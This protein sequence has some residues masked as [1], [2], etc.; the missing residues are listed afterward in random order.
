MPLGNFVELIDII[1]SGDLLDRKEL[2]YANL[3]VIQGWIGSKFFTASDLEPDDD[4]VFL[5]M[6]LEDF[7]ES[8]KEKLDEELIYNTPA[9]CSTGFTVDMASDDLKKMI[10]QF[11]LRVI[12]ELFDDA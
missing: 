9:L 10:L 2:A 8:V 3:F 11:I 6:S 1:S 4:E 7:T 5:F 12:S